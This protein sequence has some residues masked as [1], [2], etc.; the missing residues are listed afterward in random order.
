MGGRGLCSPLESS[1]SATMLSCLFPVK[2]K[3]SEPCPAAG[4][5]FQLLVGPEASHGAPSGLQ[6][7][8]LYNQEPVTGVPARSG[9]PTD[10]PANKPLG[11]GPAEPVAISHNESKNI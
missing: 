5:C 1:V 4:G 10:A 6:M 3:C 2:A 8:D 11:R 7:P 9:I